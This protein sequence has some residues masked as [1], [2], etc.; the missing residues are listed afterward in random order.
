MS[1]TSRTARFEVRPV[2]KYRYAVVVEDWV[3][4]DGRWGKRILKSYGAHTVESERLARMHAAIVTARK[5]LE[6]VL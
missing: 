5:A 2:G 6:A 4:P 3:R 1:Q